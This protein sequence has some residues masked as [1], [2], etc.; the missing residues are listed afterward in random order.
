MPTL[1]FC[2]GLVTSGVLLVQRA[3]QKV[4]EVAA[5]ILDPTLPALP[6]DAPDLPGLPTDLPTDLPGLPTDL[7]AV[8]GLGEGKKFS[9]TYEVEGDGPAR[10]L[11]AERLGEAPKVL[12]TVDLPWKVTTEMQGTAFVSIVAQRV[13]PDDGSITCR[14]SVDGEQVSEQTTKGAVATTTCNKLVFN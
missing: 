2:G 4:E 11:Y 1:P 9:V 5:P 3:T 13:S 10:I 12:D 14:A 6:T 8:P 7:P